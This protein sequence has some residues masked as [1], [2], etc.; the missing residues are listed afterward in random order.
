MLAPILFMFGTPSGDGGGGDPPDPGSGA[1]VVVRV[2]ARR[3]VG[4]VASIAAG[5]REER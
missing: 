2:G 3:R 4:S 1:I 5:A